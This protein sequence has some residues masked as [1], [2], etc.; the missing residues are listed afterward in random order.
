MFINALNQEPN[1]QHQ[2]K[3]KNKDK[4]QSH[5]VRHLR[6]VQYK[7]ELTVCCVRLVHTLHSTNNKGQQTVH[8]GTNTSETNIYLDDEDDKVLV[9]RYH[10]LRRHFGANGYYEHTTRSA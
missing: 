5:T 3:H 8:M 6:C 1:G 10:H 9:L 2:K 7:L 4:Q